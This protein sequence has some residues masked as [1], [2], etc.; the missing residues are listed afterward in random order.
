MTDGRKKDFLTYKTK[1]LW[2]R[3][4]PMINP[5]MKYKYNRKTTLQ[6]IGYDSKWDICMRYWCCTNAVLIIKYVERG[7]NRQRLFFLLRCDFWLGP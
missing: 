1:S 2:P 7:F 3:V 6:W 5:F 4:H